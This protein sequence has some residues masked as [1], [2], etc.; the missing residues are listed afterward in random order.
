[1]AGV[2]WEER[3]ARFVCCMVLAFPG[4]RTA[5]AR[6]TCEGFI[7]LK[8]QGEGGIRLRPGLL[9]ADNN[10]TMAEVGLETKNRISHRAMALKKLHSTLA[11]ILRRN[12]RSFNLPQLS[13]RSAAWLAC[14]PWEQEAGG[15]NPP[16]PTN[17]IN[18]ERVLSTVSTCC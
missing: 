14:L 3:R 2:A 10:C 18:L 6:G 12:P 7:N 9:A 15:S 8:P 11:E 5:V 1:M 16:V 17:Y 4:G 13:G